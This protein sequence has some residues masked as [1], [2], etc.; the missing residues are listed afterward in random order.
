VVADRGDHDHAGVAHGVGGTGGRVVR[1]RHEG[2]A[3]GHVDH[4]HAVVVGRLHGP[5]E[6]VGLG[7][8]LAAEDAVGAQDRARRD[9]PDATGLRVTVGG[10][11]PGDVGAVPLA[12]VGVRVGCGHGVV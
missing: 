9:A 11:D 1:P 12:V 7:R 5:E 4:V 6:D 2:Q 8:P 10:G 3:D